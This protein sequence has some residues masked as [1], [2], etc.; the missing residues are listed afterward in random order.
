MT[1][2][3]DTG[4]DSLFGQAGQ[5][6]T[7]AAQQEAGRAVDTAVLRIARAAQAGIYQRRPCGP[8]SAL[9]VEYAEPFAGIRYALMVRDAAQQKVRE[10]IKYARQEG[11]TWVQVGEALNL[12]PLAEEPDAWIAEL[13]FDYASE[14]ERGRPFE[15]LTFPRRC[16][17]CGGLIMDR[18]PSGG[19]PEDDEPGHRA[20]CTRLAALVAEHDARWAD[21]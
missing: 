4:Y 1:D 7:Q 18:G 2:R 17:V 9:T 15:T 11:L 8:D 16:P 14:A 12:R 5:V 10:Y 19:H 20:G 6:P 13:A 21:A 3:T